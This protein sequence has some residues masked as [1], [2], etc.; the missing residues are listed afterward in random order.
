MLFDLSSGKR[1][2]VVQVVYATLALLMG[3]SL[4]LFGIGSDA[5]GGVLDALGLGSNADNN[6][7]AQYEDQISNAEDKLAT[8][9]DNPDALLNL[10][11]YR[12][13]NAS[14]QVT[15][16]PETGAVD[17]PSEAQTEL[18]KAVEAWQRYLKTD[19]Q[20]PNASVASNAAQAYLLLNDAEGAAEAQRIV[21]EDQNTAAA[22]GQVAYFLYFDYQFKA[23]DEAAAKSVELSEP[24]E[25]GQTKQQ[26]EQIAVA[27]RKEQ[28]QIEEQAEKGGK[29][30][31]E[32]Q[33]TDPFGTLGGGTGVT[34]APTP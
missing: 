29:E 33:L 14:S 5:P 11:R 15:Q 27:K 12:Y 6:S 3:G 22:W 19:P 23:G 24:S 25:R 28:E 10:T 32:Q 9:P 17:I 18:E 7:G 31:G 21:A 16:D 30:A 1:K 4:V 34:P 2:R 13:L 26:L 20:S 8:D